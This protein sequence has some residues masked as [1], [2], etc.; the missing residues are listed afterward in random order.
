MPFVNYA[1]K[2][3]N[4]KLVYYGPGLSGKTE[5]ARWIHRKNDPSRRGALLHLNTDSERT[6]FFDFMPLTLGTIGGFRLRVHVYTVPGQIH[7]AATRKLVMRSADGVVFVAD[8]Q[9]TRME[10]NCES[11]DNL[12]RDVA[13]HRLELGD[14]YIMQY[15]KRDTPAALPVAELRAA[16]NPAGWPEFE[17]VA[18]RGDGV[19]DTLRAVT[20]LA[21]AQ[22]QAPRAAGQ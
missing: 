22:L 18:I 7:Y 3:I 2:E 1:A 15:N 10:A 21:V 6:L 11:L 8:S 9:E 12:H 16:L 20:R 4:L 19:F 13:E 5:N 14:A 17:A